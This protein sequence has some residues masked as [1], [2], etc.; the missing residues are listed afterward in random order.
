[1]ELADMSVYVEV[2][3]WACVCVGGGGGGGGDV[4]SCVLPMAYSQ[5][6]RLLYRVLVRSFCLMSSEAKEHIRDK[7]CV[8][9]TSLI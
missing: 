8:C 2:G 6:F 1:M 7:N 4:R 9:R 3:K 5:S